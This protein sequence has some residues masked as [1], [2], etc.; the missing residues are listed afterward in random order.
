M[1]PPDA[2][3]DPLEALRV[4]ASPQAY[5]E[6]PS[7]FQAHTQQV[8]AAAIAAWGKERAEAEDTDRICDRQ[9][10]LLTAAANA[11][12]GE[13]PELTLWSHHDIAERI[14]ALRAQVEKVRDE[15]RTGRKPESTKSGRML[16][17]FEAWADALDAALGGGA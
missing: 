1:T 10:E 7:P 3:P 8:C 17:W 16:D 9:R 13:P 12:R 5:T 2:K 15:L 4:L 11:I 14:T 6:T